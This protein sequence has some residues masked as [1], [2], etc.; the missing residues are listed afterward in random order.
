[1]Y[2]IPEMQ[3]RKD[4]VEFPYGYN[5]KIKGNISSCGRSTFSNC[6]GTG[7][8]GQVKSMQDDRGKSKKSG[9]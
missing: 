8:N 4:P 5:F 1:M 9:M 6:D 7:E 3:P 2:C